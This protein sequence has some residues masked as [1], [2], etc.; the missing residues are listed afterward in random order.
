MLAKAVNNNSVDWDVTSP[1]FGKIS[2]RT[3][4][5]SDV[6]LAA[7]AD[8]LGVTTNTYKHNPTTFDATGG[9]AGYIVLAA[10]IMK[11]LMRRITNDQSRPKRD[12]WK[13]AENFF[14]NKAAPLPTVIRDTL[15]EKD[16]SGKKPT[17]GSS[18]EQMLVPLPIQNLIEQEAERKHNSGK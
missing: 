18:M 7:I 5:R 9:D 6:L 15:R 10:R 2:H 11:T 1:T 13:D 17:I 12:T 16:F 4:T 14:E 8:A 3:K